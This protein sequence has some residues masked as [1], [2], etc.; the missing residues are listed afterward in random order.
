MK[1]ANREKVPTICISVKETL[2]VR[3]AEEVAVHGGS[4]IYLWK[5]E[6]SVGRV[7]H[8]Y[9][10]ASRW[11]SSQYFCFFCSASGH[12][13][14]WTGSMKCGTKHLLQSHSS[15]N[16]RPGWQ[17]LDVGCH[18]IF[19]PLSCLLILVNMLK[20]K[21]VLWL[22]CSFLECFPE[23]LSSFFNRIK[24]LGTVWM[25]YWMAILWHARELPREQTQR[26]VYVSKN[27][28]GSPFLLQIL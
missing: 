6:N 23:P 28:L 12:A 26:E 11:H 14:C 4:T 19:R 1:A 21:S 25:L 5:W 2:H 18:F 3:T 20:K 9:F 24:S 10:N 16:G 8:S 13:P 15:V 27:Y 22:V 17:R 7:L